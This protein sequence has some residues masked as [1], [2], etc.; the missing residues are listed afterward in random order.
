MHGVDGEAQQLAI[1]CLEAVGRLGEA[2]ELGRAGRREVGE[3]WEENEPLALIVV[4]QAFAVGGL[5]LEA[6][7]G[8]LI[9]GMEG[10]ATSVIY[11]LL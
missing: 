4:E 1:E 7:A 8:S 6:G 3:G 5:N 2:H 11:R 9:R 10:A